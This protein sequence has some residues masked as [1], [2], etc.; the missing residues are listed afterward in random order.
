MSGIKPTQE[1]IVYKTVGELAIPLD[2]WLPDNAKNLPVLLWFHGG[3]LLQGRRD[4]LAP[5]MRKASKNGDLAVISADYR[6]APQASVQEILEDVQG[7]VKFIR[8]QLSSQVGQGILDTSRLAVSGSSAGGYLALLAGIF[9]EPKPNV[10]L[11]IYPITDPL[12]WFFITPQPPAMGRP[13]VAR[14][15]LAEFLDPK[16][17]QVA[18][19]AP[20]SGRQNMY[21]RMQHDANLAKLW[22]VPDG[23]AANKFRLSRQIYG[24]RCSPAYFLHGDA[25]TAVGVEQADEVVGAMLGCGIE[26]EYERPHG[27]DHFLDVAPDYENER[28][29]AFM[30]KHL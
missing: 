18:F 21:I 12:G 15:E 23:E 7:C 4:T 5:W 6:L 25:D 16:A 9:V 28:F 14:E 24:L 20:D 17:E 8:T 19:N 29:W 3:G 30:R 2:L 27:K 26:V 1:G 11:P 13:L 10:V 22:H